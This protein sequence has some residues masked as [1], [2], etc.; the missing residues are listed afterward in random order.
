MVSD[1]L[2]SRAVLKYLWYLFGNPV[3]FNPITLEITFSG[4]RQSIKQAVSMLDKKR[5]WY[6]ISWSHIE[7]QSYPS[8]ITLQL[9]EIS[10]KR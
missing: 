7:G 10:L 2:K 4:S 6:D 9:D 8:G 3:Q 5:V 1:N